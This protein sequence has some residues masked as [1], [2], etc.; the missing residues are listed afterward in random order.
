MKICKAK[1]ITG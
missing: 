1:I